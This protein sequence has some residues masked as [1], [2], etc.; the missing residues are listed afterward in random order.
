MLLAATTHAD[1]L[2]AS[3]GYLL[4]DSDIGR[5]TT[6]WVLN[7]DLV[8]DELPLGRTL[9]LLKLEKGRYQWQRISVPYF[10]LPHRLDLSDDSRWGFRITSGRV[11]YVGTLIVDEVRATDNVDVRFVNRLSEVVERFQKEYPV[12]AAE[13]ELVYSGLQR[14]D[15]LSAMGTAAAA[16]D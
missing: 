2:P 11:N 4:I 8:V 14:D 9:R 5:K 13:Y 10:D 15:Y 12:E 1:G 3:H 7:D 6:D 16:T